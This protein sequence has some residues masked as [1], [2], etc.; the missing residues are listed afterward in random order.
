MKKLKRILPL[1][2]SVFLLTGCDYNDILAYR[3][4]VFRTDFFSFHHWVFYGLIILGSINLIGGIIFR[5]LCRNTIFKNAMIPLTPTIVASCFQ[6]ALGLSFCLL[7]I[8]GANMVWHYIAFFYSWVILAPATTWVREATDE[9]KKSSAF[10]F[11]FTG[12][13]SVGIALGFLF[14]QDPWVSILY[15]TAPIHTCL[16]WLG[17]N[18][19]EDAK[20]PGATM[21]GQCVYNVATFFS[22][23]WLTFICYPIR[24][25][26]YILYVVH[27][28]ILVFFLYMNFLDD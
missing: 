23:G 20:D 12:I 1:L 24:I 2:V 13:A 11:L 15:A 5:V 4:T 6:F 27:I 8:F 7:G 3:T 17:Y 10:W 18:K 19:I 25:L 22:C 14:F 21:A 16:L 28:I 9:F 26:W